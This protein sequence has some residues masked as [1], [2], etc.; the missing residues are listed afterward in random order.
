MLIPQTEH[1]Q[2]Q[3]NLATFSIYEHNK[4][5]KILMYNLTSTVQSLATAD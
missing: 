5:S 4:I 1:G 3:E 2:T